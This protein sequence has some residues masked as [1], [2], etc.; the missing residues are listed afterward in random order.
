MILH[1]CAV[2]APVVSMGYEAVI[3]LQATPPDPLLMVD[4]H[5]KNL[6]YPKKASDQ[7]LVPSSLVLPKFM[8][9]HPIGKAKK[10]AWS[11]PWEC[12]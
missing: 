1:A 6:D 9:G 11:S 2:E 7:G 12:I 8:S 5:T 4:H 3:S 10:S